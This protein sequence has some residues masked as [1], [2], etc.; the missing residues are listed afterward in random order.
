MVSV[1]I[2]STLIQMAT[3]DDLRGRVSAVNS[4]FIAT[5]NEMGDFRAGAMA[6]IL[7]ATAT[8]AVGGLMVMGVAVG[9]YFMFPG[10]RKLS[11]LSD[12]EVE[13]EIKRGTESESLAKK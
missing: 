12:I 7:P 4:I 1:T 8:V 5:S 9:G 13:D 6:T 11:K 10:I 3:P 2:R